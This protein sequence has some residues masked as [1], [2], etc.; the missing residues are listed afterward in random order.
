MVVPVGI[1]VLS[2]PILLWITGDGD[3]MAGAG[4][5]SAFWSV[6]LGL[7]VG[8]LM[9]RVQGIMTLHEITDM[10]M[11]GVGGLIPVGVLLVLAFGIGDASQALGTGPYVA[12]VT[13][14]GLS[15]AL[16][17]AAL[18]IVS[19]VIAFSTGTSF[20]TWAIMIPIV[21]PMIAIMDLHAGLAVS[22]VIGGGL[23]GD[24]TSPISDSTIIATMAAGADHVDHVRT[25]LPYAA[26]VAGVALVLYLGFGF[27]L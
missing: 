22:A 18:F 14:A 2:L 3:I 4:T 25:Q 8:G 26:A 23:F 6:I 7:T 10:F 15:P 16:V 24:H 17:P 11:K 5:A 27:V 9:Y 20:G 19:G 13:E 21:I 1:V 12:Q